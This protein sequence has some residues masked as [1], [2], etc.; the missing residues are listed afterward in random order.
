MYHKKIPHVDLV[1][2]LASLLFTESMSMDSGCGNERFI[3]EGA[4]RQLKQFTS[5]PTYGQ[6]PLPNNRCYW[7][8]RPSAGK[9]AVVALY[10]TSN[11]PCRGAVLLA[12][13]IN[14]NTRSWN[15]C[16]TDWKTRHDPMDTLPFHMGSQA[17]KQLM[18]LYQ[19]GGENQTRGGFQLLYGFKGQVMFCI[20]PRDKNS[21]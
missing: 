20:T 17:G 4:T 12:A 10:E 9:Y 1:V 11:I 21:S 2:L 13:D 8:F 19:P 7:E 14:G 3:Q 18:L 5:H 6:A 16:K 15:P